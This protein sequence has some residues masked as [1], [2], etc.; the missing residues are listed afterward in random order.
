MKLEK[1]FI[2]N[3]AIYA[4]GASFFFASHPDDQVYIDNGID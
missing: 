2:E 1:E 4:N 3:I